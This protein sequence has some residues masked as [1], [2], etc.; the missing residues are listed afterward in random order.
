MERKF[1]RTDN[2][3]WSKKTEKRRGMAGFLKCRILT[4]FMHVLEGASLLI[5]VLA[6]KSSSL[7]S[8]FKIRVWLSN[9]ANNNCMK[10]KEKEVCHVMTRHDVKISQ[11]D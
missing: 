4:C 9:L 1:I 7:E 3:K 5:K 6:S 2:G 10:D 11:V 8:E